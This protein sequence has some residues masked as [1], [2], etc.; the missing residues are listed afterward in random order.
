VLL[1]T[2]GG[3]TG[4]DPA[5]VSA[6]DPASRVLIVTGE[7]YAGHAWKQTAPVLRQQIA[8]DGRLQVDVLEDLAKLA[9]ARLGTY[10]AVVMHFKNYD[11]QV[12]GR[13]ALDRLSDY[14]EGGGGLVLVHFACGAFQEFPEDFRKIAGRTWNPRLRGHDPYGEFRVEIAS[15]THPVTRGLSAFTVTDELYTC[16]A[17]DAPV[18]VLATAVSKVDGRTYPMAFALA[19]GR[20]RVF[21]C[22]L[23]HDARS[24]GNDHV[25]R[26]FHRGACWVA[27]RATEPQEKQP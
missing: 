8:Q 23:G 13:A 27:G 11:P 16:L 1:V 26:L 24:L 20:G 6:A 9:S 25:G 12:P 15:A 10:G 2:I 7:D 14:V 18:T 5:E 19:Y 4:L 21:H 3:I 17:G 22:V